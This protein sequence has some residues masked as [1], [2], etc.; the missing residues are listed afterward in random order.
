[1]SKLKNANMAQFA[2]AMG[3]T[4]SV[5]LA[6]PFDLARLQY[7]WAVRAGLV[8]NSLLS[9]AKFGRDVSSLEQMTLGPWARRV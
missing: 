4:T 3:K 2:S 1:M 8:K 6:Q 5:V 9:S 7:A